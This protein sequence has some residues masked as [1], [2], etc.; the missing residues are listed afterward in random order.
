MN[1]IRRALALSSTSIAGLLMLFGAGQANAALTLNV[2]SINVAYQNSSP[3]TAN[4]HLNSPLENYPPVYIEPQI[5]NG[6]LG[7]L[8]VNLFAYCVDLLHYSGPGSYNVVSLLSHLNNDVHKYN[9]LA[10]LISA[11]GGPTSNTAAAATQTAVWELIYGDG[12]VSLSNI[13]NDSSL[14]THAAT[15]LH[16][17]D[18]LSNGGT[19]GSNLN[20]YVAENSDKQDML[21]WSA[22][23]EPSTWAMMLLGFGVIGF[24][25][26]RRNKSLPSALLT[27]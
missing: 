18:V 8:D 15:L 23:P 25:M 3:V 10:A 17:A 24:S 16:N 11:N 2:S 5:L 6:T 21:F 1:L 20:L 26:R 22:V 14:M 4:L 27:N 13:S 7:T 9:E 19:T 12:N